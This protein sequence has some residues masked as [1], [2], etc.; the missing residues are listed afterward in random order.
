MKRRFIRL[1]SLQLRNRTLFQSLRSE[2]LDVKMSEII[3]V[4]ESESDFSRL[5]L[6]VLPLVLLGWIRCRRT[7][8]SSKPWS[9]LRE[10]LDL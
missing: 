4:I 1:E 5:N 8:E 9:L 10:G 7:G 6:V 3:D 2:L